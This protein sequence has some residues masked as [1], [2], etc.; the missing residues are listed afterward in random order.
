M[1]VLRDNRD[2]V[3]AVSRALAG[4]RAVWESPRT[5]AQ[6]LEAFEKIAATYSKLKKSQ[7]SRL[8]TLQQGAEIEKGVERRFQKWRPEGF[9]R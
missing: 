3:N 2:S 7:E 8:Q 1:R 6:V 5:L 4:T 9:R